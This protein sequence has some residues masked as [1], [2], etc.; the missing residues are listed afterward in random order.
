MGVQPGNH[1]FTIQRRADFSLLLQFKD[2]TSSVIDLTGFTVYSQAWNTARTKKY[3]DFAVA[4]TDRSQGKVTI[5]L[6]DVQTSDFPDSVQYDVLLE[7]SNGS[8]EYYLQGTITVNQ[9][10]AEP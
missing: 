10:Y 7:D 1:S 6:T 3:A 8:R 2:S 9:G 4:Y 5:S